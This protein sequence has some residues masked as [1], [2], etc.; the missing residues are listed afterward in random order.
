MSKK[1]SIETDLIIPDEESQHLEL[2]ANKRARTCSLKLLHCCIVDDHCDIVPFLIGFYRVRKFDVNATVDL[3]H[4][5]AHPDFSIPSSSLSNT[6]VDWNDSDLLYSILEEEGGISEFLIPLFAR[7]LFRHMVWIR[8]AY[9]DQFN[10]GDYDFKCFDSSSGKPKVDLKV[11]YYIDEG[12]YTEA[13]EDNRSATVTLSLSVCQSTGVHAEEVLQRTTGSDWILDICLDYFSTNNPFY[14]ELHNQVA[15]DL[16]NHHSQNNIERVD[17]ICQSIVYII[18]NFP[19]RCSTDKDLSEQ[20]LYD[21][22]DD[23]WSSLSTAILYD[24]PIS[25]EKVLSYY[26]EDQVVKTL[27]KDFLKLLSTTTRELIL[28]S[29]H[30][31][32]LPHHPVYEDAE[33]D[34]IIL[35]LRNFIVRLGSK[36]GKSP[37]CVTVARSTD[38]GYTSPSQA[39]MLQAKVLTMLREVMFTS[40]GVEQ[41]IEHDLCE[42]PIVKA[43]ELFFT[44]TTRKLFL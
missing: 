27:F 40:F 25:L 31:L 30:L 7:G 11:P 44:P 34:R 32:L 26:N 24:D 21:L 33:V 28:R 15:N 16:D 1:H 23:N 6:I 42:E 3:V 36:K 5:D 20:E 38:D 9:A 39:V 8:S 37:L 13:K 29:R 18:K 19:Y 17:H 2:S 41:I 10:D 43:H 35:E 14:L 22:K 12:D 4:V